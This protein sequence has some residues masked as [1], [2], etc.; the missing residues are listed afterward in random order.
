MIKRETHSV[1]EL[2]HEI[3]TRVAFCVSEGMSAVAGVAVSDHYC[4]RWSCAVARWGYTAC[5]P[6]GREEVLGEMTMLRRRSAAFLGKGQG[7]GGHEALLAASRGA[8]VLEFGD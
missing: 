8:L 4:P 6:S 7:P 5:V 3:V 2:M 1:G